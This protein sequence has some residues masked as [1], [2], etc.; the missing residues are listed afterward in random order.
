[1]MTCVPKKSYHV[2]WNQSINHSLLI[3]T[4]DQP[5]TPRDRLKSHLH[6]NEQSDRPILHHC[7]L[8]S[9][10]GSSLIVSKCR[11]D[12]VI[13]ASSPELDQRE[14]ILQCLVRS[15][16]LRSPER[17]SELVLK[18]MARDRPRIRLDPGSRGFLRCHRGIYRQSISRIA[19]V[20]RCYRDLTRVHG[21]LP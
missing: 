19:N 4:I 15:L 2:C 12:L 9:Q 21:S 7:E 1:M 16:A 18:A 17:C 13:T 5:Q 8:S 14:A 11:Y 10:I 6:S 20:Y 3:M